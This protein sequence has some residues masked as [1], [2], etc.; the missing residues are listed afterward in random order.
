LR[1]SEGT[2]SPHE[3]RAGRPAGDR[4]SD[5]AP[6]RLRITFAAILRL[7]VLGGLTILL[8]AGTFHFVGGS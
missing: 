6:D 5:V 3:T 7:T 4:P 8:L 2:S 1:G